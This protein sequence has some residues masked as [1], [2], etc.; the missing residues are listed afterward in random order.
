MRELCLAEIDAIAGGIWPEGLH[1]AGAWLG[2]QVKRARE[3]LRSD[4]DPAIVCG[5]GGCVQV[6]R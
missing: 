5:M 4:I 3:A 2:A 1:K 6:G